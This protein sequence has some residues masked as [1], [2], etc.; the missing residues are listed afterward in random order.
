MRPLRVRRNLERADTQVRPYSTTS[1][2][3]VTVTVTLT[4]TV[5]VTLTV[6]VTVTLTVTVNPDVRKNVSK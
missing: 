1:S 3:I 5:T 6:T 2:F 4:V